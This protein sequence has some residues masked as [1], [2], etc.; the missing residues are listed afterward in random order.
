LRDNR[1]SSGRGGATANCGKEFIVI[2]IFNTLGDSIFKS[3]AKILALAIEEALN[4]GRRFRWVKF[5]SE[6]FIGCQMRHAD[7]R[8]SHFENTTLACS[9][10]QHADFRSSV[11]YNVNMRNT[12]LQDADLRGASFCD[13]NF[14]GANLKGADF[15]LA[16]LEGANLSHTNWWEADLRGVK[17]PVGLRGGQVREFFH[18]IFG[19]NKRRKQ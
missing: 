18:K 8:E 14:T 4:H 9:N 12:N 11:F 5:K 15:R 17:L 10:L 19:K 2:E 13:V 16:N 7:F 3:D 6:T 1:P